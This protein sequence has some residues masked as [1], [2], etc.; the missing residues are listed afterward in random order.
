MSSDSACTATAPSAVTFESVSC[1]ETSP[2][3]L[4]SAPD[5]P[6]AP[7]PPALTPMPIG[8]ISFADEAATSSVS[9]LPSM[10][11]ADEETSTATSLSA[12]PTPPPTPRAPTPITM[13]RFEM[14]ASLDAATSTAP[15]SRSP[16]QSPPAAFS[17]V[18]PSSAAE[19]LRSMRLIAVAFPAPTPS[20]ATD[21]PSVSVRMS[22]L[23]SAFTET[24]VSP[25][26]PSPKM[27]RFAT[28]ASV[29]PPA[30]AMAT[31]P[32]SEALPSGL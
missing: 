21:V 14:S 23:A 22:S 7:A 29:V 15:R 9:S 12:T 25:A 6:T 10:P 17:V 13:P 4:A 2:P 16:V 26:S 5:P 31:P 3:I 1:A 30:S 19:T 24:S 32:E 27:V 11:S 18:R 20:A 8:L 28:S